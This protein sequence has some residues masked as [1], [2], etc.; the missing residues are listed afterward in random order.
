MYALLG[1]NGA[2]K[3]TT[4]KVASS[5]LAPI[6]GDVRYLGERV[7]SWSSDRL[8]RAGLCTI[9]EGRG[10]FPNLTVLENL[11]MITYSGVSLADVEERALLAV[12][13]AA[14]A[15]Q[16]GGRHVVGR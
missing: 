11:R 8:A 12:P 14:G 16:A 5:Q 1:P 6:S 3:S 13:P 4:L 9:P 7:N 15:A 10:I 2:G